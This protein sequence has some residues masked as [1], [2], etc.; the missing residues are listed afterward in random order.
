MLDRWFSLQAHG[1]TPRREVVAGLT[2]FAA[3]AYILAVNPQV[4]SGTGMP[5]GA[6][7]TATALASAIMTAAMGLATN[8]PIA[9]APGMG[10]NAF[11]AYT[12]CQAHGIP[13]R[14]ALALTFL[15][16][17]CFLA[18][19]LGGIRRR[20][21]EAI[22]REMKAAITGGIGLFLVFIGLQKGGLIVASPAT[23]VT[24]GK[25]SPTSLLAL[26]GILVCLVLSLRKVPGAVLLTLALVTLAGLAV[27][28]PDGTSLTRLPGRWLSTPASLAPTFLAFDFRYVFTHLGSLLP[29]LLTLLFVDLFDNMGTL[30]G[31]A[32]RLG[33]M[34]DQ[35]RLPRLGRALGA[36]A[37]AAM[38]GSALG[39]STVTSYI[40][41]AA[42]VEEGGRT[43]LTALVVSAC[44][45]LALFAAPLI[46][47][48][49][50]VATTPALV[51]VGLS[52]AQ[53]LKAL[54]LGDFGTAVPALLTALLMPLTFSIAEG[55]AFGFVA[56]VAARTAQGRPRELTI[57]AWAL[58]GIFLL[59]L[60]FR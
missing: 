37:C 2:T 3:M 14:A 49:P 8:Y 20:L 38:V 12:L 5:F 32:S 50:A 35:G 42:G 29:M 31:V 52:M 45:L 24:L 26:G 15:S 53:E 7:I 57:T 33:L 13:W 10:M 27:R 17:V 21:L 34:D 30:I 47:M 40:E 43:G 59:H 58:A 36:D 54:D 25:V 48:V 39:T 6:L 51:V 56:F 19:T 9:L 46:T 55:L 41:S 22:P 16:G 28:G 11:F 44:F 4:L 60:V 18:A 23:L 1:T